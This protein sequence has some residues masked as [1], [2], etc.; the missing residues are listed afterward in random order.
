MARDVL[1]ARPLAGGG[2]GHAYEWTTYA[3]EEREGFNID[4]PLSVA[5]KF[6]GIGLFLLAMIAWHLLTEVRRQMR[7]HGSVPHGALLGYLA[8]AGA[9]LLILSPFED[10]GFSFGLA[11]L[12]ALAFPAVTSTSPPAVNRPGA[13]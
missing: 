12:L 7:Q 8:V 9:W 6:G 11:L 4:S 1:I 3:G 10:K 5:A 13:L 2:L